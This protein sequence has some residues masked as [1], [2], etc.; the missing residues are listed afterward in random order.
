MA[1]GAAGMPQGSAGLGQASGDPRFGQ[2][3]PG[4]PALGTPMQAGGFGFGQAAGAIPGAIQGAIQSQPMG[5][6]FDNPMA[7]SPLNGGYPPNVDYLP[8][9]AINQ[10][11]VQGLPGRGVGPVP[12]DPTYMDTFHGPA[13]MP[14]GVAP[15]RPFDPRNTDMIPLG[16]V[17]AGAL[18]RQVPAPLAAAPAGIAGLMG[19]LGAMPRPTVATAP[20]PTP[21]PAPVAPGRP[22]VSAV[23]VKQPTPKPTPKPATVPVKGNVPSRGIK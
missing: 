10:P 17:A 22:A 13:G 20:R 14:T 1:G 16:A 2:S 12:F 19:A 18:P 3:V 11:T 5:G 8:L 4:G 7:G 21:K 23:P 9:P 6:R 15:A